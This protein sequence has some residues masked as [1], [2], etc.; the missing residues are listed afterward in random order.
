M[1]AYIVSKKEINQDFGMFF[2]F[3]LEKTEK[4][5]NHHGTRVELQLVNKMVAY[6]V[7]KK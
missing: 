7:S 3:D 6:M 5:I 4:K 1:V 2:S